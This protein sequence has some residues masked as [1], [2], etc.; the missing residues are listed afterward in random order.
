[1]DVGIEMVVEP[2]RDKAVRHSNS[3][4]FTMVAV[5]D[6]GKSAGVLPLRPANLEETREG[7]ADEICNA[8]PNCQ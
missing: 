6:G 3:C 5:D 7:A 2:F 8:F 1:M 4:L